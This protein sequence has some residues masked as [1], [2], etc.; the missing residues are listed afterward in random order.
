MDNESRVV[1]DPRGLI[2]TIDR[3]REP[4]Y[5]VDSKHWAHEDHRFHPDEIPPEIH[6]KVA[7]LRESGRPGAFAR[8]G[9]NDAGVYVIYEKNIKHFPELAADDFTLDPQSA[10]AAETGLHPHDIVICAKSGM[11]RADN[12]DVFQTEECDYYVVRSDVWGRF[13]TNQGTRPRDVETTKEVLILLD[14][15][16]GK[17]YLSMNPDKPTEVLPAPKDPGYNITCY[18]LNLARFKR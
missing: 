18:V 4:V 17:N 9:D 3:Q 13:A 2:F 10:G 7:E 5:Q 12:G 11:I 14:E 1:D 15:L 6:E 16:H 8:F